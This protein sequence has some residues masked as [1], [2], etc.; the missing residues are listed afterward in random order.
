MWDIQD[1]WPD[2][3]QLTQQCVCQLMP[4]DRVQL[5]SGKV[6]E[7]CNFYA[8]DFVRSGKLFSRPGNSFRWKQL[9]NSPGHD[10]HLDFIAR[11]RVSGD[12][13]T[14][15]QDLV[16]GMGGDNKDPAH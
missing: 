12:Y 3:L 15:T 14:T 13:A 1:V 16:I 4:G 9:L 7:C 8:E 10:E 2:F 6:Q 5:R 11:R